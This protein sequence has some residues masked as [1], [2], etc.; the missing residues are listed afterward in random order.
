MRLQ[1]GDKVACLRCIGYVELLPR[2]YRS[3]APGS[4]HASD[5]SRM[6]GHRLIALLLGRA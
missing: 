5:A 4:V 3:V 6:S 1:I 2:A